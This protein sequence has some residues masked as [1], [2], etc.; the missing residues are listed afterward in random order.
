MWGLRQLA[1]AKEPGFGRVAVCASRSH[2]ADR[3]CKFPATSSGTSQRHFTP[4][5]AP[6]K[7]NL[8]REEHRRAA[9][10]MVDTNESSVAAGGAGRQHN[11]GHTPAAEAA[12]VRRPDFG[13]A[14]HAPKAILPTLFEDGVVRAAARKGDAQ[15]RQGAMA[16]AARKAN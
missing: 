12:W 8:F 10:S 6:R 9:L 13:W 15:Q 4:N 2:W 11:N 16:F 14:L 7:V 5:A 3:A 1:G